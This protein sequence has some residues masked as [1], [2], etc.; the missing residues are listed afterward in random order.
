MT[1]PI[2]TPPIDRTN[3]AISATAGSRGFTPQKIDL[4]DIIGV[5]CEACSLLPFP[6]SLICRTVCKTVAGQL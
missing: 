5:G 3:R 6:A 1:L 2:Q 4:G